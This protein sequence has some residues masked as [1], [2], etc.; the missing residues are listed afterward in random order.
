MVYYF[1]IFNFITCVYVYLCSLLI[2]FPCNLIKVC[3]HQRHLLPLHLLPHAVDHKYCW[4]LSVLF[5]FHA[6]RVG[7]IIIDSLLVT[8][9]R[10]DFVAA[11]H[12]ATLVVKK[13]IH[14]ARVAVLHAQLDLHWSHRVAS[15]ADQ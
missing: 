11:Q 4:D 1:H 6:T 2:L 15:H 5:S 10:V 9:A 12:D 13:D 14:A 8:F 3:A 7:V